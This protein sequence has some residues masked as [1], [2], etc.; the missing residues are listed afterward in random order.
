MKLCKCNTENLKGYKVKLYP[1][2]D[3][4]EKLL[5]FASFARYVYNFGLSIEEEQYQ[6]NGEFIHFNQLCKI[7]GEKRN[8]EGNEW[9]KDIP[10][11]IARFAL[12]NVIQ[13]YL[14]FF[15]KNLQNRHPRYKSKRKSKKSFNIRAERIYIYGEYISIEGFSGKYGNRILAKDH[16]IPTGKDI[17]YR[18]AAIS[19]D[20]DDFWLSLLVEYKYNPNV[21]IIDESITPKSEPIGIDVGIRNLVTTSDGEFYHLPDTSKYQ[22]RR[23]RQQRRLQ[24]DYDKLLAESNRTK[25]KYEDLPKSKNMLKRQAALRKTYRKIHNINFNYIHHMTKHIVEKNPSAIVIEDISVRDLTRRNPALHKYQPQMMFYEIH[26]QIKYKAEN[27]N[28]PVIIAPHDY[29][30]TKK[31]SRCGGVKEKMNPGQKT[32]I[33]RECGYRE[34]RDLNAAYNLR[35]LAY[36]TII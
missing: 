8:A 20:G 29:P 19:Y 9:M 36:E 33:C 10:L 24:K 6:K 23:K 13:A 2:E 22:K 14:K 27:R 25:T 16:H 4:K 15:D 35:N 7:F 31:C 12:K 21:V 26:S 28:I 32:Y 3:Q 30:S 18:N 17:R 34:D 11:T 5:S 1:D